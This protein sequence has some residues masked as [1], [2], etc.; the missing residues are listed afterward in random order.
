VFI[1]YHIL[2]WGTH[3]PETLDPDNI[4][5]TPSWCCFPDQYAGYSD[6]GTMQLCNT[7]QLFVL[8]SAY[9]NLEI[10]KVYMHELAHT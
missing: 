8:I 6:I 1:M 4:G 2:I 3:S 7:A 9:Y 5:M 10:V